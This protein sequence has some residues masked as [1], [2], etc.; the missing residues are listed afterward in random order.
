MERFGQ[1][2]VSSAGDVL[3]KAATYKKK[4]D[5]SGH[6]W[7]LR[8]WNWLFRLL[9]QLIRGQQ[10]KNR[11][12]LLILSDY[13][14][15]FLVL[16]AAANLFWAIMAKISIPSPKPSL[17]SLLLICLNYFLPNAGQPAAQFDL[18][19]WVRLG[20]AI[21]A[22]ILFVLFV[23]A[24]ASLLPSRFAA[25]AIRLDKKYLIARNI[26]VRLNSANVRMEKLRN[27]LPT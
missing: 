2:A 3:S 8:K 15:S 22:F 10:A 12:Y 1:S 6:R 13:V 19:I 18:P 21:A 16:G 14:I 25:Y 4:S 7:A 24:A 17:A 23:G 9:A 5:I 26:A 20:P 11:L 27:A